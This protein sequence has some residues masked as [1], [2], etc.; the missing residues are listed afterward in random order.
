MVVLDGEFVVWIV[1]GDA[2]LLSESVMVAS[3][4]CGICLKKIDV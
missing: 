2:W 4:R 1:S 3:Y